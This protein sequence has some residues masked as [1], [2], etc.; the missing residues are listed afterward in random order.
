MPWGAELAVH[1]GSGNLGQQKF[2][3]IAPD[4]ALPCLGHLLI[5]AVQRRDHL[6]QHQRRGDLENGVVHVFGVGA[7]LVPVKALDE[8]ENLFLHNSV[9]LFGR[10]I[11]ENRPLELLSGD[12]SLPDTHLFCKNALVVQPKHGAFPGAEVVHFVQIVDKHEIG[13]LFYHVQRVSN[14]AG[15]ENFP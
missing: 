11:V 2:I 5:N 1:P 8:G 13:H 12:G 3:H 14:T 7:G 4:I 15:P 10:K 6:I 9:H